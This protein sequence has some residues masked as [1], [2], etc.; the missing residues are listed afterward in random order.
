MKFDGN[1]DVGGMKR[2]GDGRGG[3]GWRVRKKVPLAFTTNLQLDYVKICLS[4]LKN[5]KLVGS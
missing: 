5:S 1:K 4:T 2:R 3:G